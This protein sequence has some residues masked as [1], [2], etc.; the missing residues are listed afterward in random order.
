MTQINP[1]RLRFI[2]LSFLISVN[3]LA[4][5]TAAVH[6]TKNQGQWEQTIRYRADIPGGYLL[7]K[8]KSLRY[9]FIDVEAR[10]ECRGP[11]EVDG[12]DHVEHIVRNPG[13]L[14][15]LVP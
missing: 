11:R 12:L 2:I 6:F 8:E 15:D 5:N 7:L 1:M 13:A 14:A 4:Q 9:V 3:L 10:V